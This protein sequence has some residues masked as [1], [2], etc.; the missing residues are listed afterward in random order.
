M[1]HPGLVPRT[2]G[3]AD[4][5]TAAA[6][7]ADDTTNSTSAAA[8]EGLRDLALSKLDSFRWI[9][10]SSKNRMSG[11]IE[12][13]PD[14][15]ISRQ[16][17][18]GVPIPAHRCTDC[19]EVVANA[20]TFD[21][22]IAL[23]KTRG[24]DAWFTV[25]PK[26]YLPKGT[27]CLACGCSEL[28]PESDIVDVWWE[29]G[30]S[31]TSVLE[32]R[33]ELSRP[34]QMYIEGTDQH[35]GWFQ[36]AYLTSIGA[37]GVPPW[38]NLFTHGF[39]VDGDGRKMSK[40]IGNVIS[41]IDVTNKLGADIVR[42]WVATM[43]SSGDVSVSDEILTRVSD[44]YRRVRNSL[45]FLLGNTYDF[46]PATDAVAHKDLLQTD[47]YWMIRLAQLRKAITI[48]NDDWKFYLAQREALDFLGEFS[49]IYID[50][51]KDRLYS[52]L[53]DSP[54]RRS[55]QTVLAAALNLLVKTFAPVLVFT[56]E[57][58][59][60]FM[61]DEWKTNKAGEVVESVHLCDWP[62]L[63]LDL[64][65]EEIAAQ[66]ALF[67]QVLAVREQVTKALEDARNEKL[68]GKSQEAT[69]T[70]KAPATVLNN[71]AALDSVLLE[72][73]FIVSEVRFEEVTEAELAELAA[74]A[75]NKNLDAE[76]A[77]ESGGDDTATKSAIAFVEVGKSELDKCPRCWNYRELGTDATHPDVC[78]RCAS[79]LSARGAGS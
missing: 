44:S 43:D 39:T 30:V 36:S 68:V 16:R 37:Y 41:P 45:R 34:A 74:A 31:H 29:S 26:E 77:E 51:L 79:V 58:T 25:D 9:P 14:W 11:M 3:G 42:M 66:L 67:E 20:E 60:S 54:Q 47:K 23:F 12:N 63:R 46:N 72:E 5:T 73:A 13:R 2:G 55:A 75:A 40:S 35:R 24:A 19:D 18:W 33:P 27:A 10:D 70:V 64:C 28:K 65:D 1:D 48:H 50:V 7:A 78:A 49:A 6:A 15:C 76:T 8:R 21:A 22:I 52:D 56:C 57:E 61:A 4:T 32:A 38:E 53:A 62:E 69:V 59:W 17:S 71:L